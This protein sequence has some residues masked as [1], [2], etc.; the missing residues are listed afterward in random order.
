[1]CVCVCVCVCTHRHGFL[2]T[3]HPQEREATLHMVAINVCVCM[4][5]Y[6]C[7]PS[8]SGKGGHSSR[9]GSVLSR[10]GLM[11][12]GASSGPNFLRYK[13][14]THTH[15]HTHRHTHT[16]TQTR[17]IASRQRTRKIAP[18]HVLA[19]HCVFAQISQCLPEHYCHE[20]T[21]LAETPVCACGLFQ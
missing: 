11:A 16:D 17:K 6:A 9:G 4:C 3:P 12:G 21:R 20:Y 1:M 19:Q 14:E 10:G 2:P 13:T 18:C 7:S 15:T 8:P 5:V